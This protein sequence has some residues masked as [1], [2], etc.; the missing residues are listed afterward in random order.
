MKE[1]S[2]YYFIDNNGFFEIPTQLH[3]QSIKTILESLWK[4]VKE[5][6]PTDLKQEELKLY[7][8][9]WKEC[10]PD[11]LVLEYCSWSDTEVLKMDIVNY[12]LVEFQDVNEET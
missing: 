3:S 4:I 11:K 12:L 7:D 6:L 8:N 10:A 2:E 1:N 5:N 9:Q